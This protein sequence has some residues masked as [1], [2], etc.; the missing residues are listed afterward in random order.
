MSWRGSLKRQ[1]DPLA[2]A[3]SCS[4]LHHLWHAHRAAE[5]LFHRVIH[6]TFLE[7]SRASFKVQWRQEEVSNS[8]TSRFVH[9]PHLNFYPCM[10]E[11]ESEFCFMGGGRMNPIL[12][13]TSLTCWNPRTW[14]NSALVYFLFLPN[15]RKPQG[16]TWMASFDCTAPWTPLGP[17]VELPLIHPLG[18]TEKKKKK[19]SHLFSIHRQACNSSGGKVQPHDILAAV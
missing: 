9:I 13:H 14:Q 15:R 4:T 17:F 1:K 7:H 16:L 11:A 5:G 18:N 10:Q 3:W 12:T 2:A 19:K 6:L 8:N